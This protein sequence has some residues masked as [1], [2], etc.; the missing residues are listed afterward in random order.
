MK[1]KIIFAVV[2]VLLLCGCEK[3]IPKLS[4]GDE[5]V[6]TFK[7]ESKIS[8]NDL[9]EEMKDNYALQVLINM[10]DKKI[11][12]D[13]YKD[14]LEDAK[15]YAENYAS[16]MVNS[17]G[18]DAIKQYYGTVDNY[19]EVVRLG[20][21]ND[22]ATLDY[23]KS[24]VKDSEVNK[25]YKNEVVGDR[26][27]SHILIIPAVKD[28]MTDT[29]KKEQEDKALE[30]AKEVIAKLKKGETFESLA[31]EYSEDEAT[32]DKAGSLGLINKGDYGSDAFDTEVYK[33]KVGTYS[34]TPVKTTKGYE[35]IYVTSE[36]DKKAL[37]DVKDTIVETLAKE[38]MNNDATVSVLAI[39]ELRKQYGLDIVDD[40]I[41]S[42]YNKYM[43]KLYDNAVEQNAKN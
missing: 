9:Y 10:I 4:N 31:K 14:N 37:A 7:D 32:K 13:K 36:K 8:V 41:K 42:S 28:N 6:V 24:Q 29:E 11:L 15:N 43:N 26:E 12:E 16:A 21:L 38:K 39:R 17:Y 20:Y 19:K 18:E 5:A 27:V 22:K 25:Y 30:K 34:T 33:L 35:V 23:A 40:E 1:K 2:A 3:T